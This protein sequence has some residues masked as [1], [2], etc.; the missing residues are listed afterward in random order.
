MLAKRLGSHMPETSSKSHNQLGKRNPD[1]LRE[2]GTMKRSW[3][4]EQ[5]KDPAVKCFWHVWEQVP[6]NWS[7]VSRRENGRS[8]KA[9]GPLQVACGGL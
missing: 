8:W 5:C 9:E 7:R 4:R 6:C 1:Q 3:G 2:G